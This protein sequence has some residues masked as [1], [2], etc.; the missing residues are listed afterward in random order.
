[1]PTEVMLGVSKTQMRKKLPHMATMLIPCENKCNKLMIL[2]ENTWESVFL[3][4][5]FELS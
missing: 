4:P 2:L 1:M 3:E 5:H